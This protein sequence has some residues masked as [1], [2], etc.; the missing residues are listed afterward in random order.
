[1]VLVTVK[2]KNKTGETWPVRALLRAGARLPGLTRN[3]LHF[4][5]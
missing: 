5:R 3:S 4:C 1:M 2:I